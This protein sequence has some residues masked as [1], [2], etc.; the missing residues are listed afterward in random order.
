[1]VTR[2]KIPYYFVIVFPAQGAMQGDNLQTSG[3]PSS[4][5]ALWDGDCLL[6]LLLYVLRWTSQELF[7]WDMVCK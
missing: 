4:S 7:I 6:W 1:M 5:I 3:R 2:D